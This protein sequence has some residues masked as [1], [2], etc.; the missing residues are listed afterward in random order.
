MKDIAVQAVS[1][2]FRQ[3]AFV[4][5]TG[6]PFGRAFTKHSRLPCFSVGVG[7][8]DAKIMLAPTDAERSCVLGGMPFSSRSRI[9]LPSSGVN[10]SSASRKKTQ[11]A[12]RLFQPEIA[13]LSESSRVST[14]PS[15][16]LKIPCR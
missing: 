15:R 1:L 14:V 7:G 2:P 12:G 11:S 5:K 3:E 8:I 4:N 9:S 10:R 13:L 6:I 16:S